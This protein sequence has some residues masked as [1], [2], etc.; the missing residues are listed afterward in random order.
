M[1]E[2]Q[3]KEIMIGS[4]IFEE[5]VKD[6]SMEAYVDSYWYECGIVPNEVNSRGFRY[7]QFH[8]DM[9][10]NWL[11]DIISGKTLHNQYV[12]LIHENF[13][14][15]STLDLTKL[16]A[17]IIAYEYS[18]NKLWI[19]LVPVG[20]LA[21]EFVGLSDYLKIVTLMI[22]S[23]QKIDDINTV[24]EDAYMCYFFLTNKESTLLNWDYKPDPVDTPQ[25]Q[26][27]ELDLD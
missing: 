17:R 20:P 12:P 11:Q 4:D 21:K 9:I 19:E 14:T 16:C 8:M 18:D 25:N 5:P 6:D 23:I 24:A 2:A 13:P 26:Q 7:T 22:G 3:E 27:L 1:N 10:I 15:N